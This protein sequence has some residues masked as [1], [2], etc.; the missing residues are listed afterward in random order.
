MIGFFAGQLKNK[1]KRFISFCWNGKESPSYPSSK[2]VIGKERMLLNRVDSVIDATGSHLKAV[3]EGV[4]ILAKGTQQTCAGT[5]WKR[6]GLAPLV[7]G[8][9]RRTNHRETRPIRIGTGELAGK[10]IAVRR[11]VRITGLCARVMEDVRR[12]EGLLTVRW[13]RCGRGSGGSAWI[14]H[15]GR[16]STSAASR[17]SEVATRRTEGQA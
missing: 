12:V 15:G 8:K 10:G 6:S 2:G 9:V 17:R 5:G 11:L 7:L 3:H 16:C 14:R 1:V 13:P 4:V